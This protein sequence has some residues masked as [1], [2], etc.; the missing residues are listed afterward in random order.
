MITESNPVIQHLV[1]RRRQA[2]V[3]AIL[4]S[5]IS[6]GAMHLVDGPV[7]LATVF[8]VYAA[9]MELDVWLIRLRV[10]RGSYGDNLM[11]CSEVFRAVMRMRK[12][13]V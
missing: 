13:S 11:E 5:V 8:L 1:A 3:V 6:G 4:F 10:R 9:A 12:R 7:W 2:S